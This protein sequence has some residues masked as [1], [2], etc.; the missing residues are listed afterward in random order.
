[1]V[2]DPPQSPLGKGGSDP[3]IPPCEGGRRGEARMTRVYNRKVQKKLRQ[4]LRNEAPKAERLLWWRFRGKQV[5]GLKFRR[6]YGVG[7]YVI[8]LYCPEA[9][10]AVEVDG[11]SHF[12][13]VAEAN[14]A[15]R[16]EFIESFG[17]HVLRFT[18]PEVYEQLDAV[19]DE[20]WRV[21]KERVLKL[22]RDPPLSPLEQGGGDPP[23]SPLGKGGGRTGAVDAKLS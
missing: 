5:D 20:I 1:V 17:I 19:V 7:N 23:D 14:D 8:D 11:E 3:R 4:R 12:D 21:A 18:N 2:E 15:R 10:L 16:Q 22:R 6:Q 9:K 13:P